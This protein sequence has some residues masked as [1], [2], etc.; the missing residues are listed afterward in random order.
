MSAEDGQ[1]TFRDLVNVIHEH[2]AL[3]G[4]VLDHSLVVHDLMADIDRWA[5]GPERPLD[6]IDSPYDPGAKTPR[7]R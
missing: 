5:V 1:R 3:G 4:E 7:S 6:D 2:R